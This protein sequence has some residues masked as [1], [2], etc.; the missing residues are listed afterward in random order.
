MGKLSECSHLVLRHSLGDTRMESHGINPSE[1]KLGEGKLN[2]GEEGAPQNRGEG[3]KLVLSSWEVSHVPYAPPP[4]AQG[5]R[6]SLRCL[7]EAGKET[8]THPT[9][10][11]RPKGAKG[12]SEAIQ[13]SCLLALR[14]STT[15]SQ[16]TPPSLYA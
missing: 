16:L 11:L 1:T 14:A 3:E 10:K 4:P 9:G 5:H 2:T 15:L 6:P 7:K 13:L 12:L 8:C